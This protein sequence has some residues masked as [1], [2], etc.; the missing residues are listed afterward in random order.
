M[1]Y[2]IKSIILDDKGIIYKSL[3]EVNKNRIYRLQNLEQ[4]LEAGFNKMLMAKINGDTS[5][6]NTQMDYYFSYSWY[7]HRW[8]EMLRLLEI[9]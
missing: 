2:L 3:C 4:Y 9:N 5:K 7:L 6:E 8:K 1:M